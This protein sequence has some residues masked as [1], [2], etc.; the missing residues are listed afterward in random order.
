MSSVKSAVPSLLSNEVDCKQGAV[1]AVRFNVNGNYCLS[2]GSDKSVKL[3]NPFTGVLLKTYTGTGWEVLDARGSSDNSQILAG[4]LDKQLTI[5]DVE[6][7]KILRR[8]KGH[9]G[10]VNSVAFN[11]ESTVAFSASQDGSVRCYDVRQKSDPIQV[12]HEATD[13]ILSIDVGSNEIITGS[14]DENVRIYSIREG[15]MTIDYMGESVTCVQLSPDGQSVLV[16]TMD[17]TVRLID[18]VNGHL[19]AEYKG[20]INR[21]YRV[22]SCTLSDEMH[23]ISGSENGDVYVWNLLSMSVVQRLHHRSKIIH[24]ISAHPSKPYLLT[25]A[26]NHFFLWKPV[27]TD[28]PDA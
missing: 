5:F 3:W 8:Y 4:G 2:C 15:R 17:S 12:L 9:N 14:A 25:A 1:R 20:H 18:K 26:N 6:S 10:K 22:E 7:G 27:E 13:A 24:S 23:V 21:D 19:L 16:S 11:E 28:E